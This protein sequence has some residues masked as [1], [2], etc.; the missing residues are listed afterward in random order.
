MAGFPLKGLFA[1]VAG[2]FLLCSC[3]RCEEF[4]IGATSYAWKNSTLERMAEDMAPLGV[5]DFFIFQNAKLSGSEPLR[6]S[7]KLDAASRA[8]FKR[9]FKKYGINVA[10][11]GHVRL[12]KEAD[13]K[14]LFEFAKEFGIGTLCIEAPRE[15]LPLYEKY[16]ALTGV[17]VGLYNH[18]IKSSAA[19][20]PRPEDMLSAVEP[21]K[22]VR[23]FPDIG[24]W[25]RSDLDQVECLKKLEGKMYNIHIQDVAFDNS[26]CVIFGTGKSNLKGVLEEL[27]RQKFKGILFVMFTAKPD[28]VKYMA[29]CVRYLQNYR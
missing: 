29:P 24:H 17:R 21:F 8:A 1:A 20:Y 9:F 28:A 6:F 23:T 7:P 2:I 25:A 3:C 27:K 4:R 14:E 16:S 26:D 11:Y 10:G 5:R 18:G 15:S 22:L 19:V 12:S 13:I